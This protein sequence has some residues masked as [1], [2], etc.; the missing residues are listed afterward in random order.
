MDLVNQEVIHV[1]VGEIDGHGLGFSDLWISNM[2][3]RAL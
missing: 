3:I 1:R 2:I